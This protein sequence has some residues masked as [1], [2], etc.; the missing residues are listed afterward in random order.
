MVANATQKADLVSPGSAKLLSKQGPRWPRV[1]GG[2]GKGP[3]VLTS[4]TSSSS[5]MAATDTE[6][7]PMGAAPSVVSAAR[8]THTDPFT[9]LVHWDDQGSEMLSNFLWTT[10]PVTAELGCQIQLIFRERVNQPL[11]PWVLFSI[12]WRLKSD[13]YFIWIKWENGWK[14]LNT[15]SATH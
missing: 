3:F 13:L 4:L 15:R 5:W 7:G 6:R 10:Q 11:P 9:A 12:K 1:A 2:S 14:V 8:W